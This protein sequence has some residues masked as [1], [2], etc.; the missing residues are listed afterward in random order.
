VLRGRRAQRQVRAVDDGKVPPKRTE[1]P[2]G[3]QVT[4]WTVLREAQR[5]EERVDRPLDDEFW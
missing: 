1:L 3:E 4:I 5:R 2:R